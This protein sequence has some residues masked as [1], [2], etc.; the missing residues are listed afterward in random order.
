MFFFFE[1]KERVEASPLEL[2][3]DEYIFYKQG[4]EVSS[5]RIDLG[6]I[7]KMKIIE[8]YPGYYEWYGFEHNG[9]IL[10]KRVKGD[11]DYCINE[12][13]GLNDEEYYKR[14]TQRKILERKS[15][16]KLVEKHFDKYRWQWINGWIKGI[17]I[18]G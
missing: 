9:V 2:I 3:E 16:Y 12:G 7:P 17:C 18:K 15:C 10:I 13:K 6:E 5:S 8:N 1:D 11:L 14:F 4:M